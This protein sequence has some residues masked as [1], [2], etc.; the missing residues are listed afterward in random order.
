M[1]EVAGP[2]Q[3]PQGLVLIKLTG[4]KIGK[5]IPLEKIKKKVEQD[6]YISELDQQYRQW[7]DKLKSKSFI[8]VKL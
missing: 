7:I 3:T 6:Y 5:P 4:K 2:I 1:G 8:E